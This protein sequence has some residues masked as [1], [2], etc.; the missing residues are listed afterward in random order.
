L[1]FKYDYLNREC[2]TLKKHLNA[3]TGQRYA[4]Q[5]GTHTHTHTHNFVDPIGSD[6]DGGTVE[7][8]RSSTD[9]DARKRYFEIRAYR[10]AE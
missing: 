3:I 1:N 6:N 4:L 10:I 8:S 9:I 7:N 2:S 5:R